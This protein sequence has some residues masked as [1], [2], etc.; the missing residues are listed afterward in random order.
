MKQRILLFSFFTM[1]LLAACAAASATTSNARLDTSYREDTWYTGLPQE[2][3]EDGGAYCDNAFAQMWSPESVR[4]YNDTNISW[5]LAHVSGPDNFELFYDPYSAQFGQ[6][7][8]DRFF[9]AYVKPKSGSLSLGTSTYKMTAVY[10][11]VTYE[12]D[13][14]IHTVDATY[15]TSATIRAFKTDADGGFIGDEVL[16]DHGTLTVKTGESYY[17]NGVF[18]HSSIPVEKQWINSWFYDGADRKERWSGTETATEKYS[19]TEYFTA[20]NPGIYHIGAN[21]SQEYS[22]LI[23]YVPFTLIVTDENGND[24]G[25]PLALQMDQP[26]QNV[27]LGLE[28]YGGGLGTD[29]L[30]VWGETGRTRVYFEGYQAL[31]NTYGGWPQWSIRRKDTGENADTGSWWE[32]SENDIGFLEFELADV[33]EQAGT[34]TYEISCTWGGVKTDTIDWSVNYISLNTVP[35]GHDFPELV[36]AY[37]IGDT[38]TIEPKIQPSGAELP[39]FSW[40]V[41]VFDSQLDEFATLDRTASTSTKKV[42]TINKAGVFNATIL[43]TAD[44]VTVGKE[45]VFRIKDEEGNVPKPELKVATW[46]DFERN[47]Y[48]GTGLQPEFGKL[49]SDDFV[50]Q[51]YF[52]NETVLKRELNGS[53]VWTVTASGTTAT[54]VGLKAVEDEEQLYLKSMPSQ[55]GDITYDVSCTWD[56]KTWS[57]QYTIHF[58]TATLPNRVYYSPENQ[59]CVLRSGQDLIYEMFFENW[60]QIEGEDAWKDLS[61]DLRNAVGWEEVAGTP[62]I[63]EGYMEA[64]CANLVWREKLTLVVTE[65]DGTMKASDYT[66]FGTVAITPAGLTAIESQAFAGTQLTE[67]DIPAGVSIA[68]DAFEGTGL[69]AIYCHDQ[70]TINYAVSN[71]FIAVVD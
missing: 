14:V 27:Y 48:I 39:G 18:D 63:Y 37:Q 47:I 6:D 22:N 65:A 15:P 51:F 10:K 53:P 59:L 45:T 57:G 68:A 24:P 33:P 35:T 41:Y 49:F 64:G 4:D 43:L 23:V 16:F 36:E 30:G 11:G 29:S 50:D 31:A 54:E 56:G 9:C 62:G 55:A 69:M 5:Q 21:I 58:K 3:S 25:A 44:G 60:N 19:N 38:L 71:G 46:N 61:E 52:E 20:T 13:M 32:D 42:Y 34:V 26:S 17:L 28:N 1:I 66:P 70:D 12:G 40:S 7:W 67:V 2:F 8:M